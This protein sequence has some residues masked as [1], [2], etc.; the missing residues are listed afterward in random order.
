M[1]H[2]EQNLQNEIQCVNGNH[3]GGELTRWRLQEEVMVE[4]PR[5]NESFNHYEFYE[6]KD[7]KKMRS[8]TRKHARGTPPSDESDSAPKRTHFKSE[9]P[10]N[11][12]ENGFCDDEM[13]DA[14]PPWDYSW[15][16]GMDNALHALCLQAQS[17]GI[18]L[19]HN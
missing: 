5:E 11:L 14:E 18:I 4:T 2:D 3:G 12:Y 1:I 15:A 6:G 13:A 10:E 9:I 17:L 7:L 8:L 19:K 16:S